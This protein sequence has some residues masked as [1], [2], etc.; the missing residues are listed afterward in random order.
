MPSFS[1][2]T[3]DRDDVD[4]ARS[5][6]TDHG[7]WSDRRLVSDYETAFAA[8]NGSRYAFA[9]MS[10]R[11][12]LQAGLYAL[13]LRQGD[14]VILP[15]YTCVVVANALQYAGIKPVYA[16]IELETFGLE[17]A[18]IHRLITPNT[19]A[20]LLHHLYGLICR[21]YDAILD[22]AERHDLRVIEDCA[23]VTGAEYLGKKAGNR[24]NVAFYSSEQSKI[25]NT[26][27]GG[28]VVT[29]D[30]DIAVRL[31]DYQARAPD[32]DNEWIEKQLCNVILSYYQYKHPQRWWLGDLAE[33][34][35]GA[36][37]L[38]ST[39][40]D[41]ELGR[42][43]PRYGQRMP[44]PI[45]ALG[46]HQL[47]KVDYYNQRRRE[48][49][50]RWDAWCQRKGYVKPMVLSGST[51]VYLRYPVLV[52]PEKKANLEWAVEELGFR[53]GVWF[54]SNLHPSA[55][56]VE[57]CPN[58]DTAVQRCINLPCLLDSDD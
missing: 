54:I 26:I 46:L 15:G 42:R 8:W 47:R 43:P 6:L 50:G 35:Y 40:H 19:R 9:W 27:Q 48:T 23:H 1:S 4:L 11:V 31:R 24:G 29:N 13:G 25:F 39:T 28:L 33:I 57:G 55:R 44:S 51:P 16:D 49:A 17:A 37:R 14:E 38:V 22:L 2:M 32:P 18:S 20:I 58:A 12:S 53:P 21:D 41:E 45:A 30:D 36:Q 7:R 56:K 34:R 10:G 52:E 5:W 3:L